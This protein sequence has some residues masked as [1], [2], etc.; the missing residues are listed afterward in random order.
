[1]ERV[2]D[3][4]PVWLA[5][6]WFVSPATSIT[7]SDTGDVYI[8]GDCDVNHETWVE[9]IISYDALITLFLEAKR[10]HDSKGE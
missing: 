1:M 8:R 4:S 10:L 5:G 7:I 2:L 3:V 9:M 6:R